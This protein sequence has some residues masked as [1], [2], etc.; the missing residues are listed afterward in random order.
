MVYTSPTAS[1][2]GWGD[3]MCPEDGLGGVRHLNTVP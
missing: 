2:I 1:Q 3:I